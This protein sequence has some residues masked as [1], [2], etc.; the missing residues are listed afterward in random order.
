[1]F[2]VAKPTKDPRGD[3][4][5]RKSNNWVVGREMSYVITISAAMENL[6]LFSLY[7]IFVGKSCSHGCGVG[8][9]KSRRILGG[10]GVGFLTTPV[11]EVGFFCPTPAPGVQLD[12][13]YITLVRWEF[14]LKCCNFS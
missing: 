2:G 10:V 9:V 1:L 7:K 14:L 6:M 5:A 8:V 11:V 3:G 4:T 13:F 12:H